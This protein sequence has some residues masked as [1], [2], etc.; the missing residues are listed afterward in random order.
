MKMSELAELERNMATLEGRITLL[1][2]E[3]P[4]L[5]RKTEDQISLYSGK[6][7][8]ILENAGEAR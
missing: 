8:I 3:V 4:S 5:L 1:K 6:K 7:T 2:E